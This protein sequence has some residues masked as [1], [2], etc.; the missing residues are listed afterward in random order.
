MGYTIALQSPLKTKNVKGDCSIESVNSVL[1][2][3]DDFMLGSSDLSK[4]WDPG[5]MLGPST[6]GF[7]L[8]KDGL[9]DM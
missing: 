9:W 8:K 3:V 7:C 1:G 4:V 5:P 2:V 6:S